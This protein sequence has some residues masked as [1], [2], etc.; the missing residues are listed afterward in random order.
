MPGVTHRVAE[1]RSLALHRA[2]A[3]KLRQRP[4]L[5]DV[6]RDRVRGWLECGTVSRFWAA[7]W[8]EALSGSL[9]EVIARIVDTSE[10]SRALRQSSPFAGALDPRQR[11]EILR[12]SAG[13]AERT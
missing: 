1:E 4:E 10:H 9:D 7:A 3:R 11:W 12:R 5:L 8:D 2:V 6:A 13:D